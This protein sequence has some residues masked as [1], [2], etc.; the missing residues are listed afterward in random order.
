MAQAFR[1]LLHSLTFLPWIQCRPYMV[2]S[3]GTERASKVDVDDLQC[4]IEGQKTRLRLCVYNIYECSYVPTFQI[5]RIFAKPSYLR[6]RRS[7]GLSSRLSWRRFHL[8]SLEQEDHSDHFCRVLRRCPQP[9]EVIS[10]LC[11]L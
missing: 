10:H 8:R 2:K 6:S 9:G 4:Q 1:F 7:S 5:F 11:R 3:F